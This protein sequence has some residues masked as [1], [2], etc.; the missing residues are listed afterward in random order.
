VTQNV[1]VVEWSRTGTKTGTCTLTCHGYS[2][3]DA[4][5]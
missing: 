4:S 2:H 1:G 3:E 5:Y